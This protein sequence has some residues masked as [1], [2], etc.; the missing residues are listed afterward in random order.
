[1]PQLIPLQAVPA[2]TLQVVLNAQTVSLSLYTL[3]SP[4]NVIGEQSPLELTPEQV[5]YM[6]ASLAGSAIITCRRCL[7]LSPLLLESAYMGM[8]GE[9]VF[10]DTVNQTLASVTNPTYPGLGTQY[11][12]VYFTPADMAAGLGTTYPT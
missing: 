10:F 8:T 2:Q 12:L 3:N 6:D 11:E 1:M 9:L 4:G 5:L 7:S